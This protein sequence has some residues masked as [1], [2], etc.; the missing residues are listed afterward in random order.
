M[1]V[2]AEWIYFGLGERLTPSGEVI[3]DKYYF[4][5]TSIKILNT[6]KRRV[7]V[8]GNYS[9]TN[10]FNIKSILSYEEYD[11]NE[12][13]YR[14]LQSTSYSGFDLMGEHNKLP[15]IQETNYIRPDGLRNELLRMLCNRKK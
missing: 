2:R 12:Q 4:K 3:L 15:D 1:T 8:Y 14:Y 10:T 7:W 11:C 6:N 13:S 9:L 5:D